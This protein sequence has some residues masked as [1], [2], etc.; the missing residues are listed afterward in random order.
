M[1]IAKDEMGEVRKEFKKL[2]GKS[3]LQWVEGDC[4]G[5]YKRTLAALAN[6]NTED[7]P[8]MKPVYWAQRARDAVRDVDC[9]QTILT[10]LPSI[11]IKRGMEVYQAVYGR[12]LKEEISTKCS[13]GGSWFQWTN[14]YK[15]AMLRLCSMPVELYVDGLNDA[16]AGI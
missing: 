8:I 11:A 14:W 4:S 7:D 1:S 2:N 5:D 3:L 12:S 16:M 15:T 10:S 6:R 13:E 9:L